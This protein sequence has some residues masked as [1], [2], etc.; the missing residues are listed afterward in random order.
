MKEH[1]IKTSSFTSAN[2]FR[3]YYNK[4]LKGQISKKSNSNERIIFLIDY[5]F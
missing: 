2:E 4:T 3:V 5:E 1:N